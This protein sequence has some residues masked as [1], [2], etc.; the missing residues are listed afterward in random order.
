MLE[1]KKEA[2][3]FKLDGLFFLML[4]HPYFSLPDV[5][6]KRRERNFFGGPFTFFLALL[7]VIHAINEASHSLES[8]IGA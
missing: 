1:S 5:F 2:I 6:K 4:R 3:V 8:Q 7:L